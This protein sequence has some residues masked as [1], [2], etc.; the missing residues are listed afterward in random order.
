MADEL[1]PPTLEEMRVAI[2]SDR[3]S[4]RPVRWRW[5]VA[6]ALA[7]FAAGA[8]IWALPG[9]RTSGTATPP[10]PSAGAAVVVPAAAV[11]PTSPSASSSPLALPSEP[12]PSAPAAAQPPR[13]SVRRA[14]PRRPAP[15][16][17]DVG[18]P[19]ATKR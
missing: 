2:A 1:E 8:T 12:A 17:D 13:P 9:R 16:L 18:D 5:L 3:P 15:A 14:P 7:A 6:A 4:R 11:L 10:L 19:F